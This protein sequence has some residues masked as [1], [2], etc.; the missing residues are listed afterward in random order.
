[1]IYLKDKTSS[2]GEIYKLTNE[3]GQALIDIDH[4][5]ELAFTNKGAYKSQENKKGKLTRNRATVHRI[6]MA[7]NLRVKPRK[8]IE[9]EFRKRR[10]PDFP[11]YYCLD[12][13]QKIPDNQSRHN[14]K[15]ETF[16][17]IWLPKKK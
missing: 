15:I 16:V 14:E 2:T 17:A 12:I 4:D 8:K 13:V 6:K 3:E 10:K 9:R 11:K 5:G 7:R 1:M